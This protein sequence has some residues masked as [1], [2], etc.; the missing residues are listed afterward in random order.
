MKVILLD[1]RSF[2]DTLYASSTSGMRYQI[3]PTGDMLG[4]EQWRWLEAQLTHSDA[5]IHIIGTG[6]QFIATDQ[7][8]EKWANF[9]SARQ[10]MIDLLAKTKPRN[11]M[12]ISGDRHIAEISKMK[13]PGWR[14]EL[15]D[16]TSSGLTHTWDDTREELN[17]HRV[18][19]LI[20]Q[21]NFGVIEID[22]RGRQPA[23]SMKVLGN[24]G[25]T[26]SELTVH[27]R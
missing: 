16:F 20:I 11:T 5:A 8:Y 19:P 23:V 24:N 18:G 6:V 17:R 7:G 1:A 10:R 12:I 15:Y 14:N 9:P 13:I 2:R 4:E 25:V 22:W 3:N 21:K 27:Y 26:Y